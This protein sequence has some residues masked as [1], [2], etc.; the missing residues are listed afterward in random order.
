MDRFEAMA[1]LLAVVQ[2]G[3]LS[4][5]GRA[6]SVPVTTISRRVADL[7]AL[8]GTRLLLRTTRKM[9][10]TDA[11]VAY[12]EAARRIVAQVEEAE[13]EAAGE[14]QAPKGELVITAPLMFGRLHVLPAV[15]AF[16]EQFAEISVRLVLSDRNVHLVDDH[17]DMAVRIGRLADSAMVATRVGS[18]RSVICMSP[19]LLA[20][21]GRPAKP[22]D[23]SRIPCVAVQ[24]PMPVVEWMVRDPTTGALTRASISARLTVSTAEAAADAAIRNVGAVR[25]LH[26]QVAAAVRAGELQIV[27]EDFEPEP[28]PIHLVHAER[29]Q[30]PLKMRRFIDFVAPRLREALLR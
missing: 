25:L 29:G 4:A 15:A 3:S 13:R 12:V 18:M 17:I 21:H 28:A 1:T 7:E 26:Y 5:A 24:A 10:L 30:L 27:L 16:L 23:L 9:T 2:Q 20:R 14:F 11:G 19:A 22:E 8:L 6:L